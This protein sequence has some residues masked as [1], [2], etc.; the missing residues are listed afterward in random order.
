MGIPHQ[1]KGEAFR[2]VVVFDDRVEFIARDETITLSKE[3][4]PCLKNG[5]EP[6]REFGCEYFINCEEFDNCVINVNRCM[7]LDEIG[8]LF[9]VS[10]E[11]IRQDEERALKKAYK[12]MKKLYGYKSIDHPAVFQ[13]LPEPPQLRSGSHG[14]VK[15]KFFRNGTYRFYGNK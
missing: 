10:R 13:F 7:T 12:I 3:E 11:M 2:S 15:S 8:K 4:L 5:Y 14:E 1:Y 9:G 6:C